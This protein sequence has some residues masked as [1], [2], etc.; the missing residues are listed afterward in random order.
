M[1]GGLDVLQPDGIVAEAFKSAQG[2]LTLSLAL[3]VGVSSA[4]M[5]I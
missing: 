2:K 5:P 3:N 1:K 4:G